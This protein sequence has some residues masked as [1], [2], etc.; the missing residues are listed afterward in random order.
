M[1]TPARPDRR[2]PS[3]WLPWPPALLLL[4]LASILPELVLTLA[5]R[6]LAGPPYLRLL[7]YRMGSFQP[8]L[9]KDV[10]SVFA[11]QPVTMFATYGLLHTGIVHLVGNMAALVYLGRLTL[12]RR[13]SPGLWALYAVA[14]IGAAAM[15]ALVGPPHATM[16][17]ASG[18]LFGLLGAWCVDSGLITPQGPNAAPH[19]MAQLMRLLACAGVLVLFDFAGRVLVGTPVAWQAHTGGFLS[20][21]IFALFWPTA[22]R[23]FP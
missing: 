1:T 7:A 21:A 11:A 22:A 19:P 18:A 23:T 13:T 3:R 4:L 16:V 20:G 15:F 17:G 14:T 12:E 8:D 6:G 10:P 5:D 9:L 2:H